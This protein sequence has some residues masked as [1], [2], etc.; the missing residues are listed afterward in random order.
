MTWKFWDKKKTT[1]PDVTPITPI[2]PSPTVDERLNSILRAGKPEGVRPG[3]P[4]QSSR[5]EDY[6]SY[7]L[8]ITMLAS[9]KSPKPIWCDDERRTEILIHTLMLFAGNTIEILTGCLRESMYKP[10]CKILAEKLKTSG[11]AVR[12]IILTPDADIGWFKR[13]GLP[14]DIVRRTTDA[15]EISDPMHYIVVDRYAYRIENQDETPHSDDHIPA[16]STNFGSQT[17]S[18]TPQLASKMS[19]HH[20]HI[21]AEA[22]PAFPDID[23]AVEEERVEE[24]RNRIRQLRRDFHLRQDERLRPTNRIIDLD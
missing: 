8:Y 1:R 22:E 4:Y 15:D 3:N 13:T 23:A 7:E 12:I 21:W 20:A 17:N 19:E 10:I 18:R 16:S 11:F 9:N 5:D 2:T 6:Y 24:S 14:L